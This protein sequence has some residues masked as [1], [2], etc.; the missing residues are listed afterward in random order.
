MSEPRERAT[1]DGWRA[2]VLE[3]GVNPDEPD[4]FRYWSELD[5]KRSIIDSFRY[6]QPSTVQIERIAEVRQG[7]IAFAKLIMRNTKVSA[8]QTVALRLLHEAMMTTNKSIVC[9]ASA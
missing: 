1:S 2:E 4:D 3:L 5:R 9:E 6:H 7:A 8:D